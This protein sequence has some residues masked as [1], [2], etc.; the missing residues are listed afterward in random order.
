MD[1]ICP[2]LSDHGR[3]HLRRLAPR[4]RPPSPDPHCWNGAGSDGHV[5]DLPVHS[6]L[7]GAARPRHLR[8]TGE[9]P[10]GL[11][12]RCCHPAVFLLE[13]D[14]RNGHRCYRQ[15]FRYAFPTR[16]SFQIHGLIPLAAGIL[17]P[18]K[19]RRLFVQVGFPWAVRALAF[20]MLGCLTLSCAVMRL[21]P[22]QRRTGALVRWSHFQDLPYSTFVAGQ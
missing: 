4:L 9:W 21:R 20:L 3:R 5:H 22:R 11:D 14:D 16:G 10:V 7:A 18:I 12:V 8:R 19:M 15:Q 13:T 1:R 6:I 17:Y 2:T